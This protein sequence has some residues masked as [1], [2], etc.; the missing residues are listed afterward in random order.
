MQRRGVRQ[1]QLGNGLYPTEDAARQF[2]LD[3]E[4]LAEIFWRGVNTDYG[5][6][7]ATGERVRLLLASG[8]E[9]RL[10]HPNGTDLRVRIA[11]RPVGVSDGVISPG[12][13][14]RGGAST[15]VWLPAGEVYVTPVP[16]TAEGTAV[17]DRYFFEGGVVE[18]LRLEF[19]QGRLTAMTARSGLERLR[20]FYDA[21]LAGKDELGAVD[22]G[23]NPDVNIPE[24]SRMVGW[25][26]AG[27]VTVAVGE[28]LWAGGNNSSASGV[29]PFLPGTT[30]MVEGTPVV[31]EGRLVATEETAAR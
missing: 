4:R 23:I 19:K 7:Q 14:R 22:I 21:A 6:L 29:V 9:L 11:G 24:H 25:M 17:A 1:V 10:T 20:R 18:G 27:M 12:D 3:R 16:R 2:G 13:E 31:R 5:R 26:P 30:L 8:K 28:N 15:A